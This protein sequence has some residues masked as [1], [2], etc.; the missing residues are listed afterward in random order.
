MSNIKRIGEEIEISGPITSADDKFPAEFAEEDAT[1]VM[2]GK[3]M[4]TDEEGPKSAVLA[5]RVGL[6]NDD[7]FRP[8]LVAEGFDSAFHPPEMRVQMI[9]LIREMEGRAEKLGLS[10]DMVVYWLRGG[11][12]DEVD[13]VV[14]VNFPDTDVRFEDYDIGVLDLEGFPE[15]LAVHVTSLVNHLARWGEMIDE[16]DPDLIT[17]E[18][19]NID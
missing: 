13:A 6:D 7:D 15:E 3:S 14:D 9:R 11:V 19:L 16:A 10:C 4:K 5:V 2:F 1:D 17:D 18:D 12:R 8:S